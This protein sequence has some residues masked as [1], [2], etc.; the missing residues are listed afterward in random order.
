MAVLTDQNKLTQF[1]KIKEMHKELTYFESGE[2]DTV[3]RD[4][5]LFTAYIKSK[6]IIQ[7][8]L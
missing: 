7:I 4:F 6:I 1:E 8:Y 2:A 5:Q 3:I